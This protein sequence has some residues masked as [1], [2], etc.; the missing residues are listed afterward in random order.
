MLRKGS[1]D[2][3]VRAERCAP[4]YLFALVLEKAISDNSTTPSPYLC[5]A[6]VSSSWLQ[7][8]VSLSRAK[9]FRK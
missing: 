8:F 7:V 5:N 3:H 9:Q 4:Q 2:F 6:A 1:I